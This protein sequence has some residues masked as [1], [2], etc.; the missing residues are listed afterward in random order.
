[1]LSL[2]EILKDGLEQGDNAIEL[3]DRICMAGGGVQFYLPRL[4]QRNQLICKAL[5]QGVDVVQLAQEYELT[6][7]AIMTTWRIAVNN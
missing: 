5:R 1:M 7:K 3:L 4:D 6:P 2:L